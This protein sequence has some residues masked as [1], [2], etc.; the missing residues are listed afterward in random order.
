[1]LQHFCPG[2]P[3]RRCQELLATAP[4][5]KGQEEQDTFRSSGEKAAALRAQESLDQLGAGLKTRAGIVPAPGLL[6]KPPAD[7]SPWA[8]HEATKSVKAQL[9]YP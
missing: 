2:Q 9:K 6:T 5:A 3:G 4:A 7:G 8:S 1:M